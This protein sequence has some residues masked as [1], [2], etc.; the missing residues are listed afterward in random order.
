M[1]LFLIKNNYIHA[2]V[3]VWQHHRIHL[4]S[5]HVVARV[6]QQSGELHL[7]DCL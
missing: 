6:A 1:F 5:L 3:E 2:H 7:S 4:Y